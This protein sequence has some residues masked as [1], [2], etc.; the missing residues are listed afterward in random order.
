MTNPKTNRVTQAPTRS[1]MA[2]DQNTSWMGRRW[3]RA[4]RICP[5][6]VRPS[7]K[8]YWTATPNKSVT[9]CTPLQFVKHRP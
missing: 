3:G 5:M 7:T 1:E 6:A 4:A 8:A 9:G 2:A